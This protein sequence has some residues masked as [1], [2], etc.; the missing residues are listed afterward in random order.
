MSELKRALVLSGGGARG[1]YEAG[2]IRYILEVLPDS[3]GRPPKFD[4][5]CGTSVGAI[6]AAWLAATLENPQRSFQ[7]MGYLWRTLVFSEVVEF[8]YS[9]LWRMFRRSVIDPE[10]PIPER[11]R[12]GS[13]EG[14]FLRT[15]FFDRIIRKELPF[16]QIP[17]NLRSGVLE[18]ISVS[19]TD[20]TTGRTTVF[21]QSRSPLPPWTRDVRRVALEG[22]ITPEKVLASAAIPFLFPAVKIG[23]HWYCDGGLRQN[24][25]ISPALRLGAD[26][27][28]VVSLQSQS[29]KDRIAPSDEEFVGD[30]DHP[31]LAFVAG[32]IL[33]ALLLDPL[34]YDLT[35]L[36]RVN[37][38]LSYGGE[39]FGDDVFV[40][41]LNEVIRTHRGQGYRVVQPLLI[42]PRR[43]LGELAASFAASRSK[44]FWGSYP[45]RMIGRRSLA[46]EGRHESDLLSYL[47][48]DGGYTGQLLDMGF[49]DA[50][51]RH[52]ELVEFFSS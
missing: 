29:F 37:A 13:R 30:V 23:P 28:L 11:T 4:I 43:D 44:D 6:N 34:D 18:S 12:T 32:K 15:T 20:I 25:P 26:R 39:A 14:G 9:E 42:R 8:S 41:K 50:E 45:L 27:V 19:A 36:E 22:P 47:L 10:L 3:L 51:R 21:V 38:L 49:Q 7:R 40:D 2:V 1:A 24:T 35:V 52:D 33:D 5:V 16:Q 31:N 17:R 48:F 46:A